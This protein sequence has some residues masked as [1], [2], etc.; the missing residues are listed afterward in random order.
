MSE[1]FGYWL[2][3]RRKELNFTQEYLAEL[4]SCSTITIRKIESNE[5]RP[6]RQIA[7]R[8]A[9][10]C[11]V[12]ANR[13]FVDAAWA[14]QSP[15]PSDGGSPPEPAPSNLLPPFSSIIGRDSAIESICVQF[16]AQKARLVTIV[17]SPGVGKTRLA[18]AIG[19]QLLTHFSDGVFWISLDPIVNASLVPSL[20][21]R[22][23]G[24]HENPN[25]SIEDTIFNWLKN[26]HLLL[27]LDNCEHI[28][29]LRQ[30][31]NQLLSYCPTLSILATS[32]EV[33]HLRWEQRFPLRPLTV[34]VRGMQLDLAQLAQIPAI[35]LFL[36]RSR[37][38]NPQAELN[39]SNAR[40]ISTICMQLEG[41]PLSIEL[42]AARSAM[43]SPQM[44]VHRLN[45]QL[46]VLTQGSRDLPHR[47][48]T[49]RNAIQW[50]IDLL[51]SAE[52]F[53]L[54]ALALAPESCTLLSLEAL[55]DCYSPWP[56]SIFDG[57]TNLFD[58]SLI[59]IQQQQTDEPR[60][61]MLRVLREYVLEQL[62]EPTTIQQLRQSFASYYLNIAE[63]IYQKML[64]SRTN[65]LFQEIA[66]E[67][68]NFHT[69]ITWCL[70][71]PYDLEN[72]IKLIATL[73]D[74]LHLYG[75]QR[76]G[77][78]WLQHI[79]GL[80]EQQTVTLSPAILADAYNALGFLYYHQGN[81]NQAQHFFERVLEL[82]G[83]HTSFKHARILYNLGL[84][85][86]NKGEFLQA[87]AD[88]QASLA[89]WR[90]L[91]L[92]PGEA[93]S[94]WGLGSLALDQGL[95]THGL[96]Y[97]QQSLAI[98]QT[99]EST[100]GQVMVLSDLAELALL[101]ANPHEAE[102]IL[103]QIKTIV[104]ASN[105]TIT[106]SRI[107]LLEG[108]C[109]MQRHDFS[110][111]Q[112]CFEEAEEIAEE[113]QSTAYLAKIHLEQAK[114]A[115]VQAH[116][117]QASYHGYEGLRLATMLEHQ[118]GIA[119]AHHVLAQVYQQLA[120]PSQAEQHWQAYA[121]I[122]QHVGLVP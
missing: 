119:K 94:L 81:I 15:S 30:F 122:Y 68:Y 88:L 92:Q 43:L 75:Y 3:Q 20:I 108:K 45:N 39:A 35:A 61:G 77:I 7:A 48:Q 42:I 40:A 102:Q 71:P 16:Q 50:S 51:D 53:L 65:S 60:F 23:L 93:Y 116:Y 103:A 111:A 2:K 106:S 5:R 78:S 96:T 59:W 105:Y 44:L 70:E 37:A 57:L 8:I 22:V 56:W 99:L 49:L 100:H 1:S 54:V 52:Q 107:A 33:L 112:T 117:H 95:Y 9:K 58:K 67:Y 29:E 24:I 11:Q 31:V 113:Q 72:A 98:W 46:N 76:E 6:S 13:A 28:I 10:F 74:F 115:L 41:L 110:H 85:K 90:T 121:A 63:T 19:Q 80:I 109:A 17:G 18:Q 64:N 84:V 89:S 120:N 91:G 27:I 114:L 47:Q 104:E 82:I 62:A 25:Q 38:I 34:P 87:E 55:A 83:G 66:A 69:V 86:K 79:L 97:L 12:E 14:G 73:I 101:Q 36:E 21:T 118:T 4:V 26:R 32:R